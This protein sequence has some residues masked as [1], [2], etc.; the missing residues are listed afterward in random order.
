MKYFLLSLFDWK[1]EGADIVMD[2]VALITA[3]GAL[4]TLIVSVVQTAKEKSS[5][6]SFTLM[7]PLTI[8]IDEQIAVIPL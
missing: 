2:W 3:L 5:L 8:L 1:F 4:V 7:V 6:D